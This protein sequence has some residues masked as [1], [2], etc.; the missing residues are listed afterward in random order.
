MLCFHYKM[1]HRQVEELT[2]IQ[3]DN[4]IRQLNDHFDREA[5]AHG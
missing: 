2:L 5:K 3:Y 1:T 4:L